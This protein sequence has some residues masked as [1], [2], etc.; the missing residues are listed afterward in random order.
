[1]NNKGTRVKSRV[2][3]LKVLVTVM[4]DDLDSEDILDQVTD[5]LNDAMIMAYIEL[6]EES[7]LK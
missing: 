2:V 7:N 5:A 4:D 1:M 3:T 6:D